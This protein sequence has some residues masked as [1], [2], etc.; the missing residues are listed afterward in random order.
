MQQAKD[1]L[2]QKLRSQDVQVA[3]WRPTLADE[4]KP[5]IEEAKP[6]SPVVA[7]I[8]P[9]PKPRPVEPRV[10]AQNFPA[11]A[12]AAARPDDRSLLQ[13]LSDLLPYRAV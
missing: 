5:P 13:K 8:V 6:S 3:E 11:S 7:S 2:A 1:R 10:E 12:V 4:P 9:V